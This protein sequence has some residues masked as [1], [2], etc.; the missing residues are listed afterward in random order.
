MCPKVLTV[1]LTRLC[2][3]VVSTRAWT[4]VPFTGMIGQEKLTIQTFLL[5]SWLVKLEVRWVLFSTIGTTVRLVFVS[6]NLVFVTRL[7]KRVMPSYSCVCRLRFPLIP[8]SVATAVDMTVGVSVPENRQG[9][10]CRCSYLMTGLCVVAILFDVLFSVPLKAAAMTLIW[11]TM[12]RRLRALWLRVFTNFEVREL[13]IT[14]TVP[15][16]LVRL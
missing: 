14:I 7:W 9:C 5:R 10:D 3:R 16:C 2:A 1:A 12:P 8:L 6:L 15:Q 4:C 13:L 11:L